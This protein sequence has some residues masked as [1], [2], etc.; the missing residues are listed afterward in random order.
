[1]M[2]PVFT[3]AFLCIV[4]ASATQQAPAQNLLSGFGQDWTD[5]IE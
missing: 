4:L 1:M 3:A 2:R 5:E